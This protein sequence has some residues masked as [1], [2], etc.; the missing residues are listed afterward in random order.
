M[1]E[2]T[3]AEFLADVE[4]GNV[5]VSGLGVADEPWITV[6][7]RER[8]PTRGSDFLRHALDSGLVEIESA[9][10]VLRNPKRR[11]PPP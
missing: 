11:P 9:R 7:G 8:Q 10:L 1:T 2:Y 5:F 3:Y 4:A 6:S